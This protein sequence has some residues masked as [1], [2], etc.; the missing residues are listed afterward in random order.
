MWPR[1]ARPRQPGK[2]RRARMGDAT[3]ATQA[4][5][6]YSVVEDKHLF[7]EEHTLGGFVLDFIRK[8]RYNETTRTAQA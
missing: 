5:T 6:E 8:N 2:V 3:Q 1:Q 7:P 4:K